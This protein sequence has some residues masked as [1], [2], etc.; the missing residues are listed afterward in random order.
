VPIAISYQSK[1][2]HYERLDDV[3]DSLADSADY[4]AL[5]ERIQQ[6]FVETGA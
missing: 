5:V 1:L 3:A 6:R 4:G 2:A